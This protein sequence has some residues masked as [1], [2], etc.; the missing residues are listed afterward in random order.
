[1]MMC[2]KIHLTLLSF[3]EKITWLVIV[4]SVKSR[5]KNMFKIM[6]EEK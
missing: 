1:M 5:T 4:K 6:C 3:N 2:D